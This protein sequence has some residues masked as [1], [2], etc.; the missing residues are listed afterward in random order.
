M[1]LL[2]GKVVR[3]E[4]VGRRLGFPTANLRL[5]PLAR[6]PR[7]VWRV[8]VKCPAFGER[9][10]LCNVGV[11]PTVGGRRLT[12]EVHIPGYCGDLYGRTLNVRFESLLREE[13]KFRSLSALRAQIRR[14]V[15]SLSDALEHKTERGPK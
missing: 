14:D 2:R 13:K 8:S 1:T 7:G 4:G 10:A 9:K 5:P 3:G 11:R 6:P 15:A 12:V